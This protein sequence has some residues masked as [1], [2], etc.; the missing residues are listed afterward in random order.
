MAKSKVTFES[1]MNKLEEIVQK[2]ES[3]EESLETTLELYEQGA[4]ISACCRQMLD[5]AE[6][7]ITVIELKENR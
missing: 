4:D 7:R 1:A 3:G 5:N 6:Q 2:L